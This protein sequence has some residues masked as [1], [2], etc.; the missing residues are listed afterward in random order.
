LNLDQASDVRFILTDAVG[1][2]IDIK[3]ANN[4]STET[5][6]WDIT[7]FPAGVYFL[8]VKANGVSTSKKVVKR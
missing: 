7:N 6:S 2:V 1:R 5:R 8:H 4:V 3:Y